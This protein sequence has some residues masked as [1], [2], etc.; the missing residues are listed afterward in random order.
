MAMGTSL[1]PLAITMMDRDESLE[2]RADAY[3][4]LK[5]RLKF[6]TEGALFS[7]ALVGA[8]SGIKKLRTPSTY[9]VQEYAE[10]ELGRFLQ[11]FGI[12]G[13]KPE[14]MGT[15]RV[16]ESR[17]YGIGNIR[18]VEFQAGRAVQEFDQA[19]NELGDVLKRV[20]NLEDG[21]ASAK[22]LN[23]ELIDIIAPATETVTKKGEQKF[24]TKS[25]LKSQSKAKGIGQI[26][27]VIKFRQ[28]TDE[29]REL[30]AKQFEL[31]E[32]NRTN[33]NTSC[34]VYR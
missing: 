6:G 25:L 18:S 3:R 22:K 2:G 8:G 26:E 33:K 34:R 32:L 9:G 20:Y 29:V 11:R 17:Q 13:L 23:D 28:I 21:A 27:D 31:A 15:K 10:T 14:G 12:T 30:S 19:K 1:E 5:N 4:K 16:L 7:L 24:F